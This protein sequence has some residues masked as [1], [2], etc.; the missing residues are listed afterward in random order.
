MHIYNFIGV[1]CCAIHTFPHLFVFLELQHLITLLNNEYKIFSTLIRSNSKDT[2]TMSVWIYRK[3]YYAID[4]IHTVKQ[5]ME[6][7]HG[8]KIYIELLIH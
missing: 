1:L 3:I 5:I 8:C 6:K 4:A 7:A 2:G